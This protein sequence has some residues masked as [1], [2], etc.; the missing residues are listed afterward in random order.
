MCSIL[1]YIIKVYMFLIQKQIVK[2]NLIL[3]QK[4]KKK[5]LQLICKSKS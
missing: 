2:D 1:E 3:E 5:M 4:S